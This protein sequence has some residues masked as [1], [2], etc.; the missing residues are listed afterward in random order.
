MNVA[1]THIDAGGFTVG[2]REVLL[3][4]FPQ[5]TLETFLRSRAPKLTPGVAPV[6]GPVVLDGIAFTLRG[7][8]IHSTMTA[9]KSLIVSW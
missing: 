8:G 5:F 2:E 1:A 7:R 9:S 3:L 4:Y 6:A